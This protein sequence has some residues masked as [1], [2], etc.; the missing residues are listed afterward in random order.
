MKKL[1]LALGLTGMLLLS[2]CGGGGGGTSTGSTPVQP[3]PEPEGPPISE[4]GNQVLVPGFDYHVSRG[5]TLEM[6]VKEN[7]RVLFSGHY[8]L[9]HLF[10]VN[11]NEVATNENN[12]IYPG[13]SYDFK[14]GQYYLAAT[15]CP[16][17][18]ASLTVESNVL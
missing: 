10:D 12:T 13:Q 15:S 1:A 7:G 2:G 8:C 11:Y 16:S 3:A 17:S 14:A 4:N 5:E 18:G 6:Y 9:Y